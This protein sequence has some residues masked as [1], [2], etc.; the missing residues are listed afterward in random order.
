MNTPQEL[1]RFVDRVL[2]HKPKPKTKAARRQSKR[3]GRWQPPRCGNGSRVG[4]A[5]RN[6]HPT[7]AGH[8]RCTWNLA[9][10]PKQRIHGRQLPI[11]A[12]TLVLDMV[13]SVCYDGS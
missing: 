8:V 3:A 9:T 5:L 13:T 11:R 10:V 7:V 6:G 2:A 4:R 12:T 1:D